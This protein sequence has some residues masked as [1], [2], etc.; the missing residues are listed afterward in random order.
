MKANDPKLY[1]AMAEPLGDKVAAETRLEEFAKEVEALRLKHHMRN[2][3]V[4][5]DSVYADSE[6]E[7]VVTG[8]SVRFGSELECLCLATSVRDKMIEDLNQ[9]VNGKAKAKK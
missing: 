3:L 5:T 6:G 7:E 9:T 1:R 2:V 4:M 8:G